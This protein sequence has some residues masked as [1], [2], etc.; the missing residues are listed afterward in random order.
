MT[1][2]LIKLICLAVAWP[3]LCRGSAAAAPP[4]P[5]DGARAAAHAS[6]PPPAVAELLEDNADALLPLLTNPTGDPGEGRIEREDV[7][8]GQSAVKII[9][10][11]R[12]HPNLPGWK[13][14]IAERP[15]PGEY[16][17]VRFAWKS[18]GCLGVMLQL[19]DA[20]DWNIRY[21]AGQDAPGW[22]CRFVAPAPPQRWVVV[23]R[24]LFA[25]FG[26][27]TIT[28]IALTAFGGRAAYFDHIYFGRSVDDLDR[29]DATAA[30]R[31]RRAPLDLPVAEMDRLWVDLCDDDASRSY[32]AFWTLVAAK[33][34]QAVP[35]LRRKALGLPAAAD[36]P[37]QVRHWVAELGASD[38][39]VRDSAAAALARQIG[40]AEDALREAIA[41]D[42]SP[43]VRTRATAVLAAKGRR[44]PWPDPA[45]QAVRALRLMDD[46]SARACLEELA[47]GADGAPATDA[48][49]AALRE[50]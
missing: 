35:F 10:M 27:R 20:T 40:P 3:L 23:T 12:F 4:P 6:R 7:F 19:H 13:Y 32:R 25:D 18:D 29:I 39:A 45:R 50:P 36:L 9:P 47:K 15:G 14:R 30:A 49:R 33:P 2:T 22:G 46:P 41:D 37:A 44:G 16:R 24:D 8:S 5:S 17:Y 38:P 34:G 48:A 42:P 21:T 31:E 11:Q 43:E 28:G 1:Y 26:E